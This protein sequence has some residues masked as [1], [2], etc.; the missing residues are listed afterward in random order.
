[1]RDRDAIIQVDDAHLRVR[2]AGHG[3]AIL[4]IHGW[5]LDLDMW[6]PQFA[7]MTDRYRLIAFDR[8][9]FGL[10]SGTPSVDGDIADVEQVLNAAAVEHAAI[11]GMS[12]G[13]RVALRSAQRLPQRVS[14]IVLDG[15]PREEAVVSG[16]APEIPMAHFREL[17]RSE[18][19]AAVRARWL[20]HPL[21]R[22]HT[23]DVLTTAL[24]REIVGR[25]P[26]RDLALAE[27]SPPPLEIAAVE[28]P[29]LV[30][31]GEHDSAQR[32]EVAA[33]L[34]RALPNAVL[35]VIAGAGHLPNLDQP[36]EYN[37]RLQQFVSEHMNVVP[38]SRPSDQR[39]SHHAE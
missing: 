3:P 15:A 14:C 16:D 39:R 2:I 31:S 32:R 34:S 30:I 8:R 7:A 20:Q 19:V 11:V 12:Q 35:A 23:T 27:S 25:Y 22:L 33:E 9:G 1:M 10:S 37:G 4:F 24:L 36:I 6:C 21:M 13:A 5:A 29:A 26:G 38:R 28:K 18:G 17:A